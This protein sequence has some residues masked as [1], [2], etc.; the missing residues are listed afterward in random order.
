[1]QHDEARLKSLARQYNWL[2]QRGESHA[3]ALNNLQQNSGEA[4]QPVLNRLATTQQS[5]TSDPFIANQ[6]G[7]LSAVL[8][9]TKADTSQRS[10]LLLGAL[11]LGDQLKEIGSHIREKIITR[12][13]YMILLC[14]MG[15]L[16][17]TTY[18]VY[19]YPQMKG[20]WSLLGA[21]APLELSPFYHLG[22]LGYPLIFL[23]LAAMTALLY[24]FAIKSSYELGSGKNFA[25]PMHF[26]PGIAGLNRALKS[27]LY[28]GLQ[29]LYTR[30]GFSAAQSS[31]LADA[32]ISNSNQEQREAF[33][34]AR[35][36]DTLENEIAYQQEQSRSTVESALER[37]STLW[38]RILTA[39]TAVI[40]F[41]MITDY[42]RPLF[43]MGG[44]V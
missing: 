21:P 7:E 8:D 12:Y 35:K 18:V 24:F 13:S 19:V 20:M 32:M 42:Y 37:A 43:G 6:L 9:R 25:A 26:M 41:L 17:S 27:Y 22:L 4:Y 14:S 5:A 3:E 11:V 16:V 15:F 2:R 36:L 33:T 40:I 23:I 1:M 38:N 30:G 10:A 29:Q 31:E 34:V 44:A 39:I 28:V